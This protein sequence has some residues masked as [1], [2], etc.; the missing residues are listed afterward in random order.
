MTMHSAPEASPLR[1]SSIGSWTALL[2]QHAPPH[3]HAGW[4]VT[5]Y[6]TGRIDSIVDGVRYEVTGGDVLVLHPNAL[7]EEIAH[8]AYSNYYLLLEAPPDQPWPAACYAEAAH[9]VGWLL[10]RT[11]REASST[12]PDKAAMT[13]ALLRVLDLTLRRAH[14]DEH[15]SVSQTI[16]RAV[17]QLYEECYSG[18]VSISDMAR[19]VGVSSS[20]LRHYFTSLRGVSPQEALQ[21][22]RLRQALAL[23]R[24]SDLSLASIAERCGFHSASHLSRRVKAATGSS[25]GRLR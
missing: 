7:H 21:Q 18:T 15:P 1:F 9:D 14:P 10:S 11:L 3:R 5:Y 2:G 6:R 22:V 16:V 17:E 4:K 25:P 23:L 8:T 13:P 20:S 24:S 12:T 19:Q